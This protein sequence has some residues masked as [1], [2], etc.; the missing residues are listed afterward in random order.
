MIHQIE[1]TQTDISRIRF[2]YSPLT[3]LT[4]SYRILRG[5][6][7]YGLYWRWMEEAS[8]AI[9]GL[10]FPF[11]DALITKAD[12]TRLAP[13][14]PKGYI[15]DFLTPPP[16]HSVTDIED[17]FQQLQQLSPDLIRECVHLMMELYGEDEALCYLM[18]YPRDGMACLMD[19]L[20]LY[21]RRTLAH[22]WPRLMTLLENDILHYSRL[23]SV[24]GVATIFSQINPKMSY[25]DGML[26]WGLDGPSD[27]GL[28]PLWKNKH[29]L[30]QQGLLFV[31]LIF[32]ATALFH[33][34]NEPWQPA[35]L[36]TA[37]GAG[38]WYQS[39]SDTSEALELTLGAT[40]AH[41][42]LALQ[43]PTST[44]DLAHALSLSAGAVSQQLGKLHE[45]G[46]V[47]SNRNGRR[48]YY[49]LSDRG[50]KLIA[51]FH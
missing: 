31:P 19:E 45:A 6:W 49:R 7:Q 30:N 35:L 23:M 29:T 50:E 22:H 43:T 34:L 38:N 47:D 12:R 37:R 36:Y 46:L 16:M 51:L 39:P 41:V 25:A 28:H 9:H 26:R 42:L 21:W 10:D 2:A 24:D 5:N 20:R 4:M 3:E 40:K 32:G 1:L 17:E 18:A 44:S 14:I 33:Q 11:M 13:N 27:C 48:V 8:H 15:A